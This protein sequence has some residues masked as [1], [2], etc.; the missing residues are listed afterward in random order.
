MRT[1]YTQPIHHLRPSIQFDR[2]R[3]SDS[4][5]ELAGTRP[6]P[7]RTIS[8]TQEFELDN[9][10]LP[11][12]VREH[13]AEDPMMLSVTST[14]S[15]SRSSRSSSDNEDS[16]RGRTRSRRAAGTDRAQQRRSRKKKTNPVPEEDDGGGDNAN[17]EDCHS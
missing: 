16:R 15:L 6:P 2:R 17:R 10:Q 11:G 3:N 13:V 1:K 4:A 14:V 7:I 9:L 5:A 12:S 8:T